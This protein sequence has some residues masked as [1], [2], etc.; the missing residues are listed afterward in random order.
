MMESPGM[1]FPQTASLSFINVLAMCLVVVV[2]GQG[3]YASASGIKA[4][5]VTSII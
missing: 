5:F 4:S 2:L 3:I 1:T